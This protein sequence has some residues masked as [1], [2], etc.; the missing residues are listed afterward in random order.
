[1]RE[2]QAQSASAKGPTRRQWLYCCAAGLFAGTA[3]FAFAKA[4]AKLAK[5]AVSYQDHPYGHKHC[6][7]CAHYL[8]AKDPAE[9]GHCQ[10]VAGRIKA[11]GY[12]IVWAEKN[13]SNSC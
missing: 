8:A 3:R 12:C 7:N 1:M 10:I 13:P 11:Q 2:R 5:G 4:E 6:A 9:P